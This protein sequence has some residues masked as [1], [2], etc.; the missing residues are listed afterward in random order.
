MRQSDF[1]RFGTAVTAVAEL[2]GKSISEGAMVLWWQALERFDIEQVEKALRKCVESPESGQFMPKPADVIKAIDGTATDRSL[3]AWG[4]VYE[5]MSRVGAYSSVQFSDAAIH[6][7]VSDVGGWPKLCRVTT[8]ELPFVQRRFLEAHRVY[9]ERGAE[10]APKYLIG[11]S[12]QANMASGKAWTG[13]PVLI[14]PRAEPRM[15]GHKAA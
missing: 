4:Q 3:L 14:G 10:G 13:K 7:A 11:E 15:I 8:D 12:E 9:S 5:A 1:K 2:Y 6:Q